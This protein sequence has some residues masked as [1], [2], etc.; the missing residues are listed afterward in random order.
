MTPASRIR[1]SV[2][3]DDSGS[4]AS[5]SPSGIAVPSIVPFVASPFSPAV[6]RRVG[7]AHATRNPKRRS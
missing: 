1:V 2:G 4:V 7:R 6:G 3:A 5:R